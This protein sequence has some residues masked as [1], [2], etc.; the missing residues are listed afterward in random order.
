MTD[1]HYRSAYISAMATIEVGAGTKKQTFHVHRDLISFYSGYFKAALKGGFAEAASG[2]IKL[3]TEEP[4]VFEGFVKWLYTHKPRT[5][6]ITH[7]DNMQYYMQIVKL[8]IFADRRGVPLLM[9]EMIDLFHQ[10]VVEIWITPG[11]TIREVYDNTT[12]NST[13]RR[14]LVDVYTNLAGDKH[15][16][17]MTHNSGVYTAEF[18]CDLVKSLI[19]GDSRR[20]LLSAVQ[21]RKV[22]MC[23]SF[24]VHEEGVKCTKKGIK[25][26]SGEMEK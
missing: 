23:P 18:Y 26:P 4:A 19:T 20:P 21:F 16:P 7:A 22:E 11:N 25:R 13:L 6:K 10:S 12:E 5:D 15:V 8:W 9:N 24:H 17:F 2:V 3:E 1:K 14:L